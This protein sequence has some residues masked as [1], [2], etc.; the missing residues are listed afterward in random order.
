MSLPESSVL[1]CCLKLF[2]Y[3]LMERLMHLLV[4]NDHLLVQLEPQGDA[5]QSVL[6]L[7]STVYSCP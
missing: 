2:D 7:P 5:A 4:K 6:Q 3:V 1:D